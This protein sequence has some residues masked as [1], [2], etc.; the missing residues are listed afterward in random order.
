LA[1]VDLYGSQI[2]KDYVCVGF[3]K[4]FGLALIANDWNPTKSAEECRQ[5][6]HKCFTVLYERDCHA[7]DEVQ[8]GLVTATGI[9]IMKPERV[10]STWN[11]REFRERRNEKLWQ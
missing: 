7:I 9:E 5:I 1:S 3:S 10:D 8:M 6:L 4:Y 11:L 2:A